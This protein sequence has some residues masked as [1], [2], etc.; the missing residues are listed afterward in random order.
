MGSRGG[1]RPD[2]R[3]RPDR[4]ERKTRALAV[5]VEADRAL[6]GWSCDASTDCCRFSVTGRE[7]WVTQVE[8]ELV[9]DEVK[10]Q[11]RRLPAVPDDDDGR[12]PFLSEAGRC[13]V[14]RVRPLGCRTFF[15]ERARGPSS[16]PKAALRALP[17]KLEELTIRDAVEK[18]KD[19]GARALRSWLH[20]EAR[21]RHG[22]RR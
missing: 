10:R 11:G 13:V 12:C 18:G 19:T 22:R 17:R 14:Y 1:D 16:M 6:D 4:G 9:V 3:D 21:G 20:E 15:C 7:P 2:P 8:W 5:L